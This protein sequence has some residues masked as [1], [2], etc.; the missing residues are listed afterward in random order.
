MF[1]HGDVSTGTYV[2]KNTALTK[3]VWP[4]SLEFDFK[5]KEKGRS[6]QKFFKLYWIVIVIS[7]F[8]KKL[9]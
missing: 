3:T 5:V 7:I 8:L 6:L 4:E 9:F 1:K 2:Q